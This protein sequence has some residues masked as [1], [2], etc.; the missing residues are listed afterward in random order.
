MDRPLLT[1]AITWARFEQE[2]QEVFVE[3][4]RR[5]AAY[6][7][8][9]NAEEPINLW[10]H[11][12]AIRVH[13]EIARTSGKS[14]PFSIFFDGRSQPVPGDAIGDSRLRKRPDFTCSLFD[15]QASDPLLCQWNYYLECKR[16]G[17]P[18]RGRAFNDLYSGEGIARFITTEHGY[19]RG[20]HIASMIGYIQTMDPPAILTEVNHFA[21]GRAIPQLTQVGG[22]WEVGQA[23]RLS[24]E[25]FDREFAPTQIHLS[26][27]WIDLRHCTFDIPANQPPGSAAPDMPPKRPKKPKKPKPVA[28]KVPPPQKKAKRK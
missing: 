20:C 13:C 19:A 3:S 2:I 5:L 25:P 22:V 10:L 6:S 15:A 26:H 12:L 18:K 9:P 4:L 21:I 8:L 14:L 17:M 1:L 24:H 23:N 11:W 16:L 7:N 27:F 28:T